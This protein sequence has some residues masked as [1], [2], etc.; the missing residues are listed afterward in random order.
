M[1]LSS[2]G[3]SLL[4]Q[5]LLPWGSWTHPWA[6]SGPGCSLQSKGVSGNAGLDNRP[7]GLF[8]LPK[9]TWEREWGHLN[10]L[11]EMSTR[12]FVFPGDLTRE[13]WLTLKQEP[14]R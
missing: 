8:I 9:G 10:L 7:K 3:A 2:P 4:R 12:F 11:F 13:G 6:G 5:F 1:V 14:F